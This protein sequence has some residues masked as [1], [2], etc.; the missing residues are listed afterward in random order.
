MS[1]P[2][3]KVRELQ[4]GLWE[5]R[6]ARGVAPSP[7][8]GHACAVVGE[9]LY[10]F[11]GGTSSEDGDSCYLG[12][13]FSLSFKDGVL[14]WEGVEQNGDL[15][16]AREG[17]T[18]NAVDADL[19]LFGGTEREGVYPC[20]E[21]LFV[22]QTGSCVWL[23]RETTGEAPQ[24]QSLTGVVCKEQKLVTFGGVL[25][26]KAVNDL[27]L[28]DLA[29]MNWSVPETTGTTPLPRCDHASCVVGHRVYVTGGSGSESLWFSDLHFLD[30]NTLAWEEV[31]LQGPLP[32]PR[33]YT[34]ITSLCNW[35]LG[36]FGGFNGSSDDECFS[37][38]HFLD[39]TEKSLSWQ[40]VELAPCPPKRYGHSLAVLGK[41]LV[42]FGGQ[43]LEQELSDLWTLKVDVPMLGFEPTPIPRSRYTLATPIPTPRKVVTPTPP[44]PA[45]PRDFEELRSGYLK[46]INDM[47]DT[48]AE[49]FQQL[50]VAA[51]TLE[52]ERAAFEAER[53]S[54]NELYERQQQELKEMF[55]SHRQQNEEWVEKLRT[56]NDSERKALA[57]ER[58]RLDKAGAQLATDQETFQ[59]RSKKLDAIMRQV[60]GLST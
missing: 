29:S 18:L 23:C 47:F 16:S 21:G 11:G 15:P 6:E 28:L 12:D 27:H 24:A 52:S 58:A 39:L 20:A 19:Y 45:Q 8:N 34:A 53:K 30:V 5:Q 54:H 4:F 22:F 25:K 56:E 13:L 59:Q 10:V 46:R 51:A 57:E 43:D 50:D 44:K 32:A 17:A 14:L 49:R 42:V 60:Q 31:A 33:D 7:R 55:D 40:E 35:Y 9:R 38:L 3:E 2:Q 37:D 48:L 1:E 36:L 26:G 41:R